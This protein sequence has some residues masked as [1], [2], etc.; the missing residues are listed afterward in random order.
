MKLNWHAPLIRIEL[1]GADPVGNAVLTSKVILPMLPW[2]E[3]DQKSVRE[4]G[5]YAIDEMM[6]E[7]TNTFGRDD[8]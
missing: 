2:S 4:L 5:A 7:Y 1:L 8:T 3:E 6:V